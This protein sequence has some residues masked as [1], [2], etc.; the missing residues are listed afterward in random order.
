[1]TAI[2]RTNREPPA[3]RI[4]FDRNIRILGLRNKSDLVDIAVRSFLGV[5]GVRPYINGEEHLRAF[6]W[7][8]GRHYHN[9]PYHNFH[10]AVDTTNVM[11][12]LLTRPAFKNNLPG[13]YAFVLLVAALVHDVDHPGTDNHWE[14]KNNSAL[15][16]KYH[17]R[18]VL[19]SQSRDLALWILDSERPEML[20]KLSRSDRELF[21]HLLDVTIIA[22]DFSRHPEFLQ[23]LETRLEKGGM[24]FS[25]P[26][27]LSLI[28]RTLIKSADISNTSK[29]YSQAKLWGRR[30]MREY[31][32]QGRLEKQRKLPLG[33][34]ND[35]DNINF[36]L[37]QAWFI[38]NQVMKLF[39]LLTRMENEVQEAVDALKIN[40]RLYRDS[41]AHGPWKI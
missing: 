11:G 37:A 27:G 13:L 32:A 26:E 36:H 41:A 1:M 21:K 28:A 5:A 39:E 19:E 3:G 34:L 17:N 12:W 25:H 22:T 6:I 2:A 7:E 18:A 35:Q 40:L 15:A 16:R 38:E 9:N 30:V 14:I 29:H 10:H 20:A 4:E 23:E 33:P 31:W 8:V 24:D